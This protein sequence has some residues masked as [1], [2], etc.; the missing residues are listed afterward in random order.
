MKIF[1]IFANAELKKE[2]L[3]NQLKL[4]IVWKLKNH[5]KPIWKETEVSF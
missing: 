1:T 4:K 2:E 5:Q 3:G